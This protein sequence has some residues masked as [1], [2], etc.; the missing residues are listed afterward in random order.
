VGGEVRRNGSLRFLFTRRATKLALTRPPVPMVGVLLRHHSPFL[1]HTDQ[2]RGFVY[3][4]KTG[5]LTEI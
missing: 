1:P 2:V 4:D 3:N 5:A